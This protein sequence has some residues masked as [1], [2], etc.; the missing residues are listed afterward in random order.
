MCFSVIN[1]RRGGGKKKY[2]LCISVISKGTTSFFNEQPHAIHFNPAYSHTPRR[3]LIP[4]PGWDCVLKMGMVAI[5]GR[6]LVPFCG[7]CVYFFI[8][9]M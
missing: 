6:E 7:Q 4:V 9:Q 3:T 5:Y 2:P 8:V 1:D